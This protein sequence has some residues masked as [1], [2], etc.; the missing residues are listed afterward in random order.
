MQP[1][2]VPSLSRYDTKEE[3]RKKQEAEK[4]SRV[5]AKRTGMAASLLLQSNR[6]ANESKGVGYYHPSNRSQ[7]SVTPFKS[8]MYNTRMKGK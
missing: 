4:A 7:S 5:T 1:R 8:D 2:W 3:E 6:S